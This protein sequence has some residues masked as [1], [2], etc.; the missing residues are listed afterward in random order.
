MPTLL[1][2]E[3]Y[4]VR[5]EVWQEA[6]MPL[7]PTRRDYLCVLC[8]EDRLGRE[9]TGADFPPVGA[10]R[11]GPHKSAVLLSRLTAP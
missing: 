8:L 1:A 5:D 10:N 6:G 4:M 2:G 9:L 11:P 7:E 3:W